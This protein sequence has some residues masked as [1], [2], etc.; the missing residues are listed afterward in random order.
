V[1]LCIAA[2]FTLLLFGSPSHAQE[3]TSQP[4]GQASPETKAVPEGLTGNLNVSF[5]SQYIWRG[6]ELSK[7]SLVIFPTMTMGYKGFAVNLWADLDTNFGNPLP[8]ES[9]KFS[10]QETD[11]IV[12]YANSLKPLKTNY[13]FG[14]IF[15]DTDGFRG[16][17]PTDNQELFLTLATEFPLK[18]TFSV[19]SEVQVA[20]AWYFS[21]GLCS[22]NIHKD[23]SLD[24]GLQSY[25]YSNRKHNLSMTLTFQP[26]SNS[27]E[28]AHVHY[29]ED[30]VF[31]P[32][33]YF[34]VPPAKVTQFQW[35]P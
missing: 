27:C 20:T 17:R 24:V 13:T 5:Y 12:T 28:Q 21:L 26:A 16:H 30:T 9:K 32:A 25:F 11:L 2:I 4:A 3:A 22:F 34:C 8:R 1:Y 7:D 10:L 23:W 29:A 19:Y 18:P 35:R 15:Y 31:V 6:I 33:E 14:W